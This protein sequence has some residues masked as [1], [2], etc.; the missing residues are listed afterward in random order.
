MLVACMRRNLN[1]EEE[2]FSIGTGEV[3]N[4]ARDFPQIPQIGVIRGESLQAE[5]WGEVPGQ[6]LNKC[7]TST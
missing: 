7:Q 5:P 2:Y 4:R 6:S 1:R 3:D